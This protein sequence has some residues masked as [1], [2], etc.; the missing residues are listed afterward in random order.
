MKV[1]LRTFPMVVTAMPE[2]PVPLDGAARQGGYNCAGKGQG[3]GGQQQA[4]CVAV[5]QSH[6]VKSCGYGNSTITQDT[7]HPPA[8]VWSNAMLTDSVDGSVL[9]NTITQVV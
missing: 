5:Q 1:S 3:F 6:K 9:R 7:H 8:P 4:S 2:N